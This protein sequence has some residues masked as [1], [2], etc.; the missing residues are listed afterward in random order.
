MKRRE[1]LQCAALLAAGAT[2]APKLW[3]L[4]SQQSRFLAAQPAYID[5][6]AA[7]FFTPDQ[8][9]VV[10]AMVQQII[11]ATETPGALEAGVPKFIE[12]MVAD[13]FNDAERSVFLD[14]L[15]EIERRSGGQFAKMS[16]QDQLALLEVLEAESADHSWYGVGETLRV[17]D[18]SAPFIC[19]FKEITVLGFL[20]SDVG[21]KQFLR[22]N[23]MGSFDGDTVLASTDSAYAMPIL[24]RVMA[25]GHVR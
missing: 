10:A 12:L 9:A 1:L 3:A 7:T 19:Q 18:D 8:R 20:L 25:G 4:T 14:G 24:L 16:V 11:P 2:A 13:W 22:S 23:S 15:V 17:W 6:Q 5:R 21:S